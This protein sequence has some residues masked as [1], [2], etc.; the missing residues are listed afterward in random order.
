MSSLNK[1]MLIGNVGNDP[2]IKTFDNGN[3]VANF[4]IATSEKWKDKTTGEQKEKTYWHNVAVFGGLVNVVKNYVKKGTKLYVEGAS[5]TRKWQD[6]EGNDRYTTEVV[7][8]G[9]NSNLILLSN[10]DSVDAV[11]QDSQ[12]VQNNAVDDEIPFN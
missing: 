11:K 1:I 3:E 12:P 8:N 10:K 6:N 2:E 9:F 4:S 5:Q 7:L